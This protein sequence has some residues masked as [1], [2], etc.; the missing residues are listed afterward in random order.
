MQ[1][2]LSQQTMFMLDIEQ[3]L[4]KILMVLILNSWTT[5][6]HSYYIMQFYSNIIALS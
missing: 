1:L 5:Y 2:I 4:C 6:F 3:S